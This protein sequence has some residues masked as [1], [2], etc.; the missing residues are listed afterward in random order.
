MGDKRLSVSG[1]SYRI[2]G[3]ADA[4]EEEQAWVMDNIWALLAGHRGLTVE[5]ALLPPNPHPPFLQGTLV[6]FPLVNIHTVLHLRGVFRDGPVCKMGA[7]RPPSII[8][9]TE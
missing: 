1:G 8:V 7:Q 2:D 4:R 9:K 6:S 3:W 5:H